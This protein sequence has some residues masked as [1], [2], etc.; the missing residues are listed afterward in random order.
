[1]ST[2][3]RVATE[4]REHPERF[5]SHPG[6]LWRV[7]H[8]RGGNDTPCP[9]HMRQAG[10]NAIE[11]DTPAVLPH[12]MDGDRILNARGECIAYESESGSGQKMIDA[13]HS[14][15]AKCSRLAYENAARERGAM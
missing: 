3:T 9:K 6:C 4:K 8:V 14:L 15:L 2:Q 5:C 7:K 11:K 12:K 13:V 10:G 1:M